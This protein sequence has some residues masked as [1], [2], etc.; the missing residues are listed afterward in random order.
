[1][2]IIFLLVF[3]LLSSIVHAKE[4]LFINPAT[5]T[6]G[7][8]VY[9][10]EISKEL[11]SLGLN[12]NLITTDLNCALAKRH[13]ENSNI[14]TLF[15]TTTQIEGSA[16]RH[17]TACFIE[18]HTN[19]FLYWLNDGLTSFCSAGEKT[20]DDLLANK[21]RPTILTM[22]DDQKENFIKALM[23]HLKINAR[24]VRVHGSNEALLMVKAQE[25]DYVFRDS[26]HAMSEFKNKCFWNHNDIDTK[27][28]DL[29]HLKSQYAKFGQA[30][31]LMAK[32][33]DKNE[34]DRMRLLLRTMMK[35]NDEIQKQIT[36]R[37]QTVFQWNTNEDF[38]NLENLFFKYHY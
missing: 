36:R 23:A 31:F 3:L 26:I 27:F 18:A 21:S 4:V 22:A 5:F 35:D 25:V 12:A 8:S 10:K 33:F 29:Q 19:N 9:A 37:G 20:W 32:N 30:M 2:N 15:I 1:M 11:K 7:Q 13:W 28:P 17:N 16:Q 14:P 34:I 6:G 38:T 24:I